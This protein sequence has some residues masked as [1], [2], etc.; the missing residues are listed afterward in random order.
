[1]PERTVCPFKKFIWKQS[2]PSSFTHTSKPSCQ[3]AVQI[4][5]IKAPSGKRTSVNSK[6]KLKKL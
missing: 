4:N 1:M 3:N 5:K 6:L 2:S